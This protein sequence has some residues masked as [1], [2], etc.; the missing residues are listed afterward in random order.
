ME[1]YLLWYGCNE[2]HYPSPFFSLFNDLYTS[3]VIPFLLDIHGFLLYLFD[4]SAMI[5][6]TKIIP[7][8]TAI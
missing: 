1:K 7:S 6:T 8:K 3:A 2:C 5:I 4:S